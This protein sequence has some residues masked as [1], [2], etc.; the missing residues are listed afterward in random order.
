MITACYDPGSKHLGE[1]V[2]ALA[3]G[4][5]PLCLQAGAIEVELS[6]DALRELA[7]VLR[8][9]WARLGVER[10]A[11]ERVSGLGCALDTPTNRVR[12]LATHLI[13]AARVASLIQGLA[14]ALDLCVATYPPRTVRAGLKVKGNGDARKAAC[15]THVEEAVDE[16]PMDA[17]LHASDAALAGLWDAQ[18]RAEHEEQEARRAARAQVVTSRAPRVRGRQGPSRAQIEAREARVI[19]GCI[20]CLRRH[21]RTC[22]MFI[23]CD[24][25]STSNHPSDIAFDNMFA[26]RLAATVSD[27]KQR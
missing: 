2:L 16:W 20:G 17:S 6:D 26:S 13:G 1:A 14:L 23:S 3:P 7:A 27:W 9:T 22:P 21:A 15:R 4:E 5:R 11:L 18:V 24:D 25:K 10:V 12:S 8:A 19:G